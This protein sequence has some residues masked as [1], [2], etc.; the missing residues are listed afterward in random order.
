MRLPA[1]IVGGLTPSGEQH[2][3]VNGG[4]QSKHHVFAAK[5]VEISVPTEKSSSGGT[6][7]GELAIYMCPDKYMYGG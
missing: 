7:G 2:L 6:G 1:C 4:S 3:P 5:G